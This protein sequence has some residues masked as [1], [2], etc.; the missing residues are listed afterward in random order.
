MKNDRLKKWLPCQS[1]CQM[2]G[3]AAAI[4]SIHGACV[5][6]NGPRWC[7]VIAERELSFYNRGYM[8]RLY[9]SHIEQCDLLFG[10]GTKLKEII[11]EI[12][13]SGEPPCLLGVL[14]SCSLGLIGDDIS[15]IIKEMGN[16]YPVLALDT[17]GLTGLF[18]DGYQE[19]MLAVLRML[20]LAPDPAQNHLEPYS[21]GGPPRMSD[22]GG[23]AT[24]VSHKCRVNLLGYSACS[25]HGSGDLLELKRLLQGAGFQV[26]V[27]LGEDGLTLEE[28]KT[29]PR[30]ALNVLLAPELGQKVADYLEEACGQEYVTLPVPYGPEQTLQWLRDIG[31][32]LGMEP[33]LSALRKEFAVLEEDI[34][35]Q[36]AL[37]RSKIENLRYRRGILELPYSRAQNFSQAL[38]D[39]MLEVVHIV[40]H[41]QGNYQGG[42][43]LDPGEEKISW[44]DGEYQILAGTSRDRILL[45]DYRR[46]IYLNGYKADGR[47]REKYKTYVGLQGWGTLLQEIFS[48]T[49]TL[50]LTEEEFEEA[51][52][53]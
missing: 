23:N 25:P 16:P 1:Y 29:I 37:L 19:A 26:G 39:S 11:G 51:G 47:I 14:T 49:L 53:V 27:C 12:N 5:V 46:T 38:T 32:A 52:N 17:G 45:G 10:T 20:K 2:N 48:Q 33:D 13:A 18:E 30:A 35:N 4:L 36:M 9:C 8:E 6:F 40:G 44:G 15:G 31:N 21:S 41:V 42:L 28:L 24:S 3:A 7:S 22:R 50:Y 43:Q 34:G